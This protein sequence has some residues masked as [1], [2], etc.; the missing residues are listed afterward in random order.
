MILACFDDA[1]GFVDCVDTRTNGRRILEV[2]D[3]FNF[4]FLS[5]S[6]ISFNCFI[7]FHFLLFSFFFFFCFF[8]PFFSFF[9][10]F[11]L[12]GAPNLILLG[13]NFVTISHNIS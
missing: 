4:H 2:E 13:L 5:F 6:F 11:F 9:L 3:F 12:L 8:F 10:F 1:E 7:F